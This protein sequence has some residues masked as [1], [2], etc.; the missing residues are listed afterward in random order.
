M[1]RGIAYRSQNTRL[2]GHNMTKLDN[3]KTRINRNG[4]INDPAVPRP[5]VTLEEFFE[6]NDDYGSI[7]YNFFPN[8]SISTPSGTFLARNA[9][10]CLGLWSSIER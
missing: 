9:S 2:H 3:L 5:L 7:G 4:D 6:G 10:R 1:E 8:Q